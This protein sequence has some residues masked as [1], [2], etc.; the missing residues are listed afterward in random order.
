MCQSESRV[1]RRNADIMTRG[2]EASAAG[3]G[4][5][6]VVSEGG[7][8]SDS[9]GDTLTEWNW[10][11]TSVKN[12]QND[13]RGWRRRKC[14]SRTAVAGVVCVKIGTSRSRKGAAGE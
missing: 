13:Q 7:G 6:A 2:R 8:C 5:R 4:Q 3:R 1:P 14:A 10:V 9:G 12:K 11:E